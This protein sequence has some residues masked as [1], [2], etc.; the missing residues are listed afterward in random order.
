MINKR[1]QLLFR[2]LF[3]FSVIKKLIFLI[4]LILVINLSHSLLIKS[5]QFR[6]KKIYVTSEVEIKK[7]DLI[8]N[9]DKSYFETD[10]DKII[11]D[12]TKKYP[13]IESADLKKNFPGSVSLVIKKRTPVAVAVNGFLTE[14]LVEA[15]ATGSANIKYGFE[16][17]DNQEFL[18]D[19]Y[20]RLLNKIEGE[21]P[22]IG[23]DLQNKSAGDSITSAPAIFMLQ[24]LQKISEKPLWIVN[25]ENKIVFYNY[26]GSFIIM[27]SSISLEEQLSSLQLITNRFRIEGRKFEYLDLRF[28]KPVVKFLK[29]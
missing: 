26:D 25:N 28:Q 17:K 16:K 12:I 21:F 3:S 19:I 18:I 23:L 22:T 14:S 1:P 9:F 27:D 13:E 24:L 4:L 5:S 11:L 20:G 2:K 15:E 10:P 8:F 7:D 6:I 29:E